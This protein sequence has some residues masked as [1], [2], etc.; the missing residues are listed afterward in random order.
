MLIEGNILFK[1]TDM[2][3]CLGNP[4]YPVKSWNFLHRKALANFV[5]E[6]TSF[7]EM[8]NR[9]TAHDTTLSRISRVFITR[10]MSTRIGPLRDTYMRE[11]YAHVMVNLGHLVSY[12]IINLYESGTTSIKREQF[13]MMLYR[14]IKTVQT[15]SDVKLHR[16]L[17]NPA[18][19]KAILTNGNK[20][21]E[22]ILQ[23]A[24]KLGLIHRADGTYSFLTALE[25]KHDFDQIR[26]QNPLAVATNEVKPVTK[27]TEALDRLIKDAH[28]IGDDDYARLLY[29]DMLRDHMWDKEKF[30]ADQYGEINSQE[31]ATESGAPYLLVPHNHNGLG[32]VLVHGFLA[33]PAELR[34]LGEKLYAR[35]HPVIGVRLKGHGTSPCD[36][37]NRSWQEWYEEVKEGYRIMAAL[38]ERVCL[39]GFSTGGTLS[40][41][42]GS[43]KPNKLAAVVAVST[44]LKFM[45][46]NMVFIPLVHGANKITNW[47]PSYEGVMPFRENQTEH[48]A[49]NYRNMPIRGLFE[50]RRAVDE[51]VEQLE[52]VECPVALFQGTKDPVVDPKSAE[53]VFSKLTTKK[54]W[55]YKIAAKRHGIVTE[56]IDGTQEKIIKFLTSNV[57]KMKAA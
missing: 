28:D 19:Y 51:M 15:L 23:A 4:V 2:D 21:L 42:L 40:L 33:S 56:N 6:K 50:L 38:A 46:R 12:L 54:K 14:A 29:D 57:H 43:E 53:I 35:G 27:V 11:M 47:L 1:D 49:I 31:T 3:I 32:I 17:L 39:V 10:K 37:R 8:F 55:I 34:E 26:I 25:N 48:P 41:L 18:V 30:S 22:E 24:Y 7:D 44:A 9:S 20:D 45:N 16:G 5:R 52:H 13:N 36:L